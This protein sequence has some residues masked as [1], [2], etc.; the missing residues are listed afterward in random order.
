M[1]AAEG[2]TPRMPLFERY[3]T[4][5]VALSIV[6]GIALGQMFAP[7]FQAVAALE[8]AQVNLP[9]ALLIWAMII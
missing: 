3:L 2:P 6:A 7:A 8:V 1:S 5:W 4:V 9:V